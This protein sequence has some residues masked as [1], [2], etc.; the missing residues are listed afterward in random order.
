LN[1]VLGTKFKIIRGYPAANESLLAM[2]RGEVD[3]SA[4]NWATIKTAKQQWL[5]DKKVKV[6][7]QDLPER[8]AD[9]PDVP[10]LGELGES[11]P[12]KQLLSLYASTGAVGRAIFAPPDLPPVIS[13]ALRD[14]FTKMTQDAEFV[15]DAAKSNAV[16]EIASGEEVEKAVHQTLN[17]PESILQR[18]RASFS[19]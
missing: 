19:R 1:A 6:I 18:A 8:A 15:A 13:K 3:G 9:L 2:E 10:A 11:L 14:G 17:M 5:R 4:A 12:D 16:L 7:L